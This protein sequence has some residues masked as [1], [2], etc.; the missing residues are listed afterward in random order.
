M[1]IY[2]LKHNNA[3]AKLTVMSTTEYSNRRKK[4]SSLFFENA[5]PNEYLVVIG[6]KDIKPVL[7]GKMFKLGKKFLRVPANVQKLTFVTDNANMDYQGIG[8]E[9]YATWRIN[10][11]NPKIAIQT[12]DFFDEDDPMLKTNE[13]LKTICVEAVRHVIANMTIE[14]ALKNKDAIAENLKS[15]LSEIERKWGIVFDQV[16]IEKVRIMSDKL[17]TDLQ[18]EFRDKLRLESSK[19]RINTDREISKHENEIHEK[20]ELERIQTNQKIELQ[21]VEKNKQLNVRKLEDKREISE[22]ERKIKEEE[23]RKEIEFNL[24]K[25]QKNSELEQLESELDIKLTETKTRVVNEKIKLQE[26]DNLIEKKK[27]EIEELKRKLS[28]TYSKDELNNLFINRLPEIFESVKIDNYSVMN[29]GSNGANISPVTQIL[30]EIIQVLKN[31]KIL[32]KNEDDS[33]EE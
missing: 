30:S 23:F 17:F 8:I 9:G 21:D 3:Q 14:N 24:E 13:H 16:G 11:E 4:T 32:L 1:Y 27:L 26:L 15:Q 19:T 33:E 25:E 12:L 2:T 6:K 5:L 29:S 22:Q 31:N 20:N 18:S 28:Q 10:P 7:G